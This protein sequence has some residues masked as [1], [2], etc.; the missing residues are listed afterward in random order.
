MTN[1]KLIQE[2]KIAA[3]EVRDDYRTGIHTVVVDY[4]SFAELLIQECLSLAQSHHSQNTD[5]AAGID[6]VRDSIK[7][8]FG[9]K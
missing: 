3:S 9:V 7:E 5:Y 2:L 8:H 6:S 1:H 4:N